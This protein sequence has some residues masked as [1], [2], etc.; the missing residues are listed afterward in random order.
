METISMDMGEKHT[1]G[2]VIHTYCSPS[3]QSLWST[4]VIQ[5]LVASVDYHYTYE[6]MVDR[7]LQHDNPWNFL[8]FEFMPKWYKCINVLEN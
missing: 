7:Q 3:L 1:P 2:F 5:V 6:N 8:I 4:S